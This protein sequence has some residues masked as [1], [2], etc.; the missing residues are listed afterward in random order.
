MRGS[1]WGQDE[2][3]TRPQPPGP[4]RKLRTQP[5]LWVLLGVRDI[6]SEWKAIDL[7]ARGCF[8]QPGPTGDPGHG[9]PKGFSKPVETERAIER[10]DLPSHR[11]PQMTTQ[12]SPELLPWGGGGNVCPS[13]S[14]GV[15]V[16]QSLALAPRSGLNN[17]RSA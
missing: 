11:Q 15:Q 12:E 17:L 1:K 16:S 14:P 4:G 6:C 9:L 3:D 7:M 5:P 2:T 10:R 8:Q 13:I